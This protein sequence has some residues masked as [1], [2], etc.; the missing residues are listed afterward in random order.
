VL[1]VL[2]QMRCRNKVDILSHTLCF[3]SVPFV[4]VKIQMWRYYF[5]NTLH[6]KF[7][8]LCNNYDIHPFVMVSFIS[9]CNDNL[10]SSV[11]VFIFLHNNDSSNPCVVSIWLCYKDTTNTLNEVLFNGWQFD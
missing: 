11:I 7:I 8:S 3:I 9:F 6:I 1:A 2:I 5:S 10:Y 4:G